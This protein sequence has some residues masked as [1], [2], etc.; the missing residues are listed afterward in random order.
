ML[1]ERKAWKQ[2][3][4]QLFMFIK[5]FLTLFLFFQI[6]IDLV[7]PVRAEKVSVFAL[8]WGIIIVNKLSCAH[9]LTF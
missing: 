5:L 6:L 1:N 4:V 3:D 9:K 7:H 8:L 2:K